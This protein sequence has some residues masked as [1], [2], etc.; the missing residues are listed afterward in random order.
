ML[1]KIGKKIAIAVSATLFVVLFS[2]WLVFFFL[3]NRVKIAFE[4]HQKEKLNS[5]VLEEKRNKLL[6]LK[7]DFPD[8]EREKNDLNSMLIKKDEAVP[9]LRILEKIASDT[10][11]SIKIEPVD[12]TKVKFEKVTKTTTKVQEDDDLGDTKNKQKSAEEKK[13]DE[14]APLKNL[15]AF[16]IEATG[17]FASLVDFLEKFENIPY[18]ARPLIIDISSGKKNETGTSGEGVLSAGSQTPASDQ[19]VDEKN[20]KMNMT[21]VVYGE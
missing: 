2:A 17:H 9:L 3:E 11:C 1:N 8:L 21:F 19:L 12:I 5:Y 16:S 7:R 20:I 18:F 10:S 13:A 6:K 4:N 15:P 14:L